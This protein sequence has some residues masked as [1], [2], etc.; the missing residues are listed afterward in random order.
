MI[1]VDSALKEREKAGNPVKVGVIGAGFMGR[2][3]VL[4]IERSIPGM[5]V[6]ALYNRTCHGLKKDLTRLKLPDINM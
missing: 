4:T 3:M 2:G 1:I 6:A 5:K